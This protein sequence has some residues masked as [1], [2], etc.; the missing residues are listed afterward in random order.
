MQITPF[1]AALERMILSASGWR[2]IFGEDEYS[3]SASITPPMR[4]I[5]AVAADAFISTLVASS[6]R[7]PN[8]TTRIVVATDS[9]PTGPAIADTV[10][11]VCLHRDI[12]VHWLGV[13]S[14]PEVIAFVSHES[15]I[16]G[17]FY[18]TAS[19]NPPGHNGFK[20][21]FSDGGV[22]AGDDAWPLIERFRARV[23]DQVYV[24][25]LVNA[26]AEIEVRRVRKLEA[27]S[28]RRRA[29]ARAAYRAIALECS[30]GR[31]GATRFL[32]EMQ[33]RLSRRPLGVVGELNGSA[34][35]TS[36]DRSLL[37]ELGLA[38]AIYNDT[39]GQFSHQILPEDAGLTE[40]AQLLETHGAE[41]PTFRIAY[42]PDNDGDRGNLVFLKDGS[43]VLLDAQT[44]FA[45]VVMTELAWTRYLER[46]HG[47]EYPPLAVVANGPTSSRIE[48]ICLTYD[49]TL[50]RA[51]VG[52]A[53][54]VALAAK[55]RGEGLH[56]VILGEGSNGGNITPPSSVRDPL[57][58]LLAMAKL[59]AFSLAEPTNPPEATGGE[60][61]PAPTAIDF[62]SVADA[63][64]PYST[65]ATDDPRAKMH[66]GAVTPAELKDQYERLLTDHIPELL[67]TLAAEYGGDISWDIHNYEGI[68][69]RRGAGART[70]EQ[71]GGLKVAFY[72]RYSDDQD[73]SS[74]PVAFVWMRGSGTEPVFR[75]LADCRGHNPE[76]LNELVSWQ[77]ELVAAAVAAVNA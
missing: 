6:P 53:N 16:D 20:M 26:I 65:L 49:A 42:V 68:Q 29:A 23:K 37:P 30:A 75:I 76:L 66:I 77:R 44:V 41:D 62:V 59:H 47:E 73:Q 56:V 55:L 18:V 11:R 40:A 27:S 12:D 28:D 74:P 63:L 46:E 67:E 21:G 52:E 43:A 22:M 24:D 39:P 51:E 60:T 10:L 70:G 15:D 72:H 25:Q 32:S 54:V 69:E 13:T 2:G 31:L 4:D 5:T 9:R 8:S 19:H 7:R 58:T 48:E 14:T 64:P 1:Q 3:L 71:R 36:I 34:R 35:S 45:L 17:F 57:S 38:T 61:G 33:R 50:Y